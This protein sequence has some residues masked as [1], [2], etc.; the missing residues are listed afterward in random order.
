MERAHLRNLTAQPLLDSLELGLGLCDGAFQLYDLS[1][2]VDEETAAV[3]R[4]PELC[5]VRLARL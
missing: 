1:T 5:L 2:A 4:K 3:G